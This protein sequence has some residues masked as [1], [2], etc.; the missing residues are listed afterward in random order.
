[1]KQHKVEFP[2][3]SDDNN[4][5]WKSYMLA[6]GSPGFISG[7]PSYFLIDKTGRVK[8]T[9]TIDIEAAI[10]KLLAGK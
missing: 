6:D 2:M 7:S 8:D 9:R 3:A 10:R 4:S 5:T 1:M